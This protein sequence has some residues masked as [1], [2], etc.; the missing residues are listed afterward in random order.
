[1][2]KFNKERWAEEKAELERELIK[3][4]SIVLRYESTLKPFRD[5]SEHEYREAKAKV[6][7]LATAISEGDY[8]ANKPENPL[9]KMTQEQLKAEYKR[10]K[11]ELMKNDET[12][13]RLAQSLDRDK[14]AEFNAISRRLNDEMKGEANNV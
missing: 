7:Q 9:D 5:I 10:L 12:Q 13:G 11:A 14:L 8:L 4:K 3:A 6:W 2:T 1:M